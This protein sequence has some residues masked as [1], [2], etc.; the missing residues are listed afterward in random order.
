MLGV[1]SCGK[2]PSPL[3]DMTL[4]EAETRNLLIDPALQKRGWGMGLGTMR[5][6]QSAGKV[7]M[8]NGKARRSSTKTAD[9]TLQVRPNG[10][11]QPV[12]VGVVEA[13]AERFPPNHGLEQ[14]KQTAE[15]HNVPFAFSSNGHLYVEYDSSKGMTTEPRS[16]DDFPTTDELQRRYELGKEFTFDQPDVIP[17]L[18][19]YYQSEDSVR[20]YQD[21]AIRAVFEKIAKGENRALLS[22]ATGTGKT[23]IAV[24][25]LK[26]I[27]DA[28]QLRRALFVCDRDELR[29][30]GW[31]A[32]N[33]AFGSDAAQAS[34]RNPEKNARVIV[35]TY[36]TLGV[37]T[38]EGDSS[39]L[40]THYPE[41]YFS[42]I[43]ID[44]CHR[45]AWNKWSEVLTRNSD[46]VQIGLT[47]TPR[48]FENLELPPEDQK[49]TNDNILYFGFPAYE[50]G[51]GRGIDDGYLALMQ[52]ERRKTFIAQNIFSEHEK[53]ITRDELGQGQLRDAYTGE[54]VTAEDVREE[55]GAPTLEQRLIMPDR[56]HATCEDLFELLVNDGDPRQKTIVFCVSID[57]A[58]RVQAKMNNLYAQWCQANGVARSDPYAFSC[59]AE[60]GREH[61]SDLRGASTRYFVATTV[62]LLSTGVDVPVVENIVFFRYVNSPIAFQQ[63]IGRGTRIDEAR[64]KLAFTI[65]DYT[66]ATRLMGS[67]LTSRDGGGNKVSDDGPRDGADEQ[68]I[69]VQGMQVHV[70]PAGKFIAVSKDDGTVELVSI[71]EY[72]QKIRDALVNEV[73]DIEELK[74]RWVDPERR[75]EAMRVLPDDTR[76][77]N[78]LREVA[79]MHDYDLFDVLAHIVFGFRPLTRI[80]RARTFETNNRSW[81]EPL[82]DQTRNT[83]LAIVSQF[84]KG[85][86][87]NL[88]HSGMLN[89]P[90]VVNAGGGRALAGYPDGD[91]GEALQ[92]VKRRIFGE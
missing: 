18:T 37:D 69:E 40:K 44:E 78:L 55:Y 72:E 67:D 51:I 8:V 21:A 12:K 17:L 57:H 20:Y 25:I 65:Y 46:A 88:E 70:S 7:R 81:L 75:R 16:F 68:I 28:G 82:P 19:P 83:I 61:I 91:A 13:K 33:E 32:L 50:Y 9:Y 38:E 35:A 4:N 36:Q 30:Q 22:L 66:D 48:Q 5:L 86:I 53:H 47:A 6:E 43:V 15:R 80:D 29:S 39:F 58:N 3:S 31:A 14:A 62:D 84:G 23:H 74:A 11:G 71:E 76:S 54:S 26:R 42:H 1:D 89:T 92:D 63:M 90:E 41:N 56:V 24:N 2:L 64:G 34:T 45:S 52:V 49:I 77:A 87:E 10:S 27:A 85:G 79:A 73:G 59:T 60:T